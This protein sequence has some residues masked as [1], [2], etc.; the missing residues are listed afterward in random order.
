MTL[1]IGRQGYVGVGFESSYGSPVGPSDY[2]PFVANTLV[3]V[4]EAIPNNAA[5]SIRDKEMGSVGGKK[6]SKG[7]LT[8]N[9][10]SKLSVYLL[11]GV[12]GSINSTLLGSG[13]YQHTLTRNNSSTPKSLTV[14]NYRPVDHEYMPGVAVNSLE[15]SVGDGLAQ[16][17][18]SLLGKFPI[19]TASGS[20]T[21]AS[22]GLFA[23]KDAQLAFGANVAAAAAATNLKPHDT[24]ITI[25]N[26]AKQVWRH[27][28]ADVD[29]VNLGE[30][31]V[32]A[33]STLY[34]ENVNEKNAFY[35]NTKQAAAF[36][37]LGSSIG[38]G[39]QESLVVNF[40]Q[41]RVDSFELE[42]GLADF[43][44][45]KVKIK[46]EWDFANSK[47]IDIVVQNTKSS[48]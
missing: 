20:L 47:T 9:I 12:M 43:Y 35:N 3:G 7:D 23:F 22:G 45:E 40:Y 2:L 48:Y 15:L 13:V 17:K 37:L 18:A 4:Q 24:K 39:Y 44:A 11:G 5:Y 27:G 8:I 41:T 30:F 38:G 33:E 21:T 25:N 16:A 34:F 1:D 32:E 29:T 31:E 10:D 36:E 6:S 28:S 46:P 19:T 26:N 42:T 14:N